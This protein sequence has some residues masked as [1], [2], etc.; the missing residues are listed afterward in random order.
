MR[1][2]R[3]A[4]RG[5]RAGFEITAERQEHHQTKYKTDKWNTGYMES[6]HDVVPARQYLEHFRNVDYIRVRGV[7]RRVFQLRIWLGWLDAEVSVITPFKVDPE[8]DHLGGIET[9]WNEVAS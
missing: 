9:A 2:I 5:P 4:K 3:Y 7:T 8:W 1:I 6:L